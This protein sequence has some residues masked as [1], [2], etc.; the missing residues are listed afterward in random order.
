[1]NSAECSGKELKSKEKEN[2]EMDKK[3]KP[4]KLSKKAY[5][6]YTE[7]LKEKSMRI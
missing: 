5:E 3:A 7:R 2:D 1:M 6:R 4:I